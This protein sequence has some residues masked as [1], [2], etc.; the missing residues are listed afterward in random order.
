MHYAVTDERINI[1]INEFR[2]ALDAQ[3]IAYNLNMYHRLF[4]T[5]LKSP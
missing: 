2:A 3:K 5:A 4:D 1:G